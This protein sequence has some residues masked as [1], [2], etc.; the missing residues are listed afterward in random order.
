MPFPA[1]TLDPKSKV[2][3]RHAD[4]AHLARLSAVAVHAMEPGSMQIER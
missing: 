4:R 1:A 3:K 2:V